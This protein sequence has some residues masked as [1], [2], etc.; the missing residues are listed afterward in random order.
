[1]D[2]QDTPGPN[3]N[4]SLIHRGLFRLEQFWTELRRRKVIRVAMTYAIVGWLIIQVA[5]ATFEGFG[6]P[7]WAYVFVVMLLLLGFPIALIIAWAFELTPEGLKTTKDAD[8][9]RGALPVSKLHER[10]RNWFSFF[11]GATVPTV[12]FSTMALI[13][14]FE[15]TMKSKLRLGKNPL[16]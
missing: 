3:E 4:N 7:L 6:I 10:K 1:M 16:P 13:F 15:P 14:Y 5:D 12:I 11:F 9:E 2:D 8:K